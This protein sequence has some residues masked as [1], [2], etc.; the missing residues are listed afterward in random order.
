MQQTRYV[1]EVKRHL[2]LQIVLFWANHWSYML[3]W[4]STGVIHWKWHSGQI[5]VPLPYRDISLLL[6]IKMVLFYLLMQNITAV[7]LVCSIII[8][9]L[10]FEFWNLSFEIIINKQEKVQL[11]RVLVLVWSG[12]LWE[13]FSWKSIKININPIME[14]NP[15]LSAF[16]YKVL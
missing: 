11:R 6:C 15:F 10:K 12:F 7:F 1:F 2:F 9:V 13:D 3:K 8:W 14:F 16:S 5:G 4:V